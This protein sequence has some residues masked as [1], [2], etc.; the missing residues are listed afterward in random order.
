MVFG[1]GNSNKTPPT[2]ATPSTPHSYGAVEESD[3]VTLLSSQHHYRY[4][5]NNRLY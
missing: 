4:S 5:I 3:T 1:G 2:T